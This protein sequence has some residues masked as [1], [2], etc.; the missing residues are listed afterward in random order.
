MI[1]EIYNRHFTLNEVIDSNN[2]HLPHIG[3]NITA[4][5]YA[6]APMHETS[7]AIFHEDNLS[8]DR[9]L[10]H[11]IRKNGCSRAINRRV[12]LEEHGWL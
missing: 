12:V 3:E 6:E 9:T 8:A 2:P 7:E 1:F 10:S 11:L 4:H 5:D